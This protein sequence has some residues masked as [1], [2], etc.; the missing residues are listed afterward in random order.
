VPNPIA[1]KQVPAANNSPPI[2]LC[3]AYA[4]GNTPFH[5]SSV[6]LTGCGS[7]HIS[8]WLQMPFALSPF[9]H[10]F[11]ETLII[12]MIFRRAVKRGSMKKQGKDS[13]FGEIS[14]KLSISIARTVHFLD[15]R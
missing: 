15:K 7:C 4:I 5:L 11:D 14:K 6:S 12:I 9:C 10:H 8:I 2:R 13:S 3:R 1:A